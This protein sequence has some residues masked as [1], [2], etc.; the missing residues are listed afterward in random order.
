MMELKVSNMAQTLNFVD[1]EF[2]NQK[3]AINKSDL[4][5]AFLE[6][7]IWCGKNISTHFSYKLLDLI[8]K[9]DNL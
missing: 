3:Y 1:F 2:N 7:K 4:I 8:C 9:A 6:I 5:K